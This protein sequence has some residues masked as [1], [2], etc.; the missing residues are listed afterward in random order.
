MHRQPWVLLLPPVLT[1]ARSPDVCV[2]TVSFWYHVHTLGEGGSQRR[3]GFVDHC[4]LWPRVSRQHN[5]ALHLCYWLQGVK[6][7]VTYAYPF[8]FT[9]TLHSIRHIAF[10][11]L[12][13]RQRQS[14]H[15]SA[16]SM[17]IG[18]S[19]LAADPKARRPVCPVQ[20]HS[21]TRHLRSCC[22]VPFPDEVLKH[23]VS[24]RWEQIRRHVRRTTTTGTLKCQVLNHS[25]KL[26][27]C[28]Y[29]CL[30]PPGLVMDDDR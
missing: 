23:G 4:S 1:A 11:L 28:L 25:G 8:S 19:M 26:S 21:S 24:S 5:T 12:F 7:V 14:H 3:A 18:T 13:L 2:C 6:Q 29:F 17:T 16:H 9:C 30:T 15:N 20:P 22:W 27:V 10:W